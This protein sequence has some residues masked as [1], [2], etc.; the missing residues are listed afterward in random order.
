M[1]EMPE[2]YITESEAKFFNAK[3]ESMDKFNKVFE[4]YHETVPKTEV[5]EQKTEVQAD[6]GNNG[7]QTLDPAPEPAPA[8]AEE[9]TES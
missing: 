8:P 4:F 6:D 2:G 1:I 9:K 5:P 7:V 3:K